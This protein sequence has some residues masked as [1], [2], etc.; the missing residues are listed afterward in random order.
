VRLPSV[1]YWPITPFRAAHQTR[2]FGSEADIGLGRSQVSQERA[3]TY[4]GSYIGPTY[5]AEKL[6]TSDFTICPLKGSA[7]AEVTRAACDHTRGADWYAQ[8]VANVLA[9][10]CGEHGVQ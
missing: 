4:F 9:R 8:M 2:R 7:A 1:A 5:G 3:R 6:A 10:A